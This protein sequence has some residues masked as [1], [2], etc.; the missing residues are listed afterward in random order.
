M[1]VG[2]ITYYHKTNVQNHMASICFGVYQPEVGPHQQKYTSYYCFWYN[3]EL[4]LGIYP[5]NCNSCQMVERENLRK[6]KKTLIG[7]EE[8]PRFIKWQ[9]DL[10]FWMMESNDALGISTN[11]QN[12]TDPTGNNCG[13]SV[14]VGHI[15]LQRPRTQRRDHPPSSECLKPH[16]TNS[17]LWNANSK[18]P[19]HN[20][21]RDLVPNPWELPRR[22][23]G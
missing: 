10:L 21:R 13:L 12:Y 11:C 3:K 22:T 1:I 9:H 6:T 7:Q 19:V 23:I 17:L 16:A 5:F 8:R 20:K 2:L 14:V 15:H 18:H 4:S